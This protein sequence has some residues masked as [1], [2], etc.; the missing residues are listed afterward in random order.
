MLSFED[1]PQANLLQMMW[2]F[3]P[4]ANMQVCLNSPWVQV[5][6]FL[7]V[8]RLQGQKATHEVLAE[9]RCQQKSF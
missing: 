2:Q 9:D 5:Q 3:M 1:R 8:R 4:M 6:P 7:R